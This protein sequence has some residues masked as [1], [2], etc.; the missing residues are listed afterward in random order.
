MTNKITICVFNTN[1]KQMKYVEARV[2]PMVGDFLPANYV[3]ER[4]DK[5][6]IPVGK[7]D[8]V[9]ECDIIAFTS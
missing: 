6:I 4:V 5:I 9:A 8:I 1:L 2:R 7:Q 3:N